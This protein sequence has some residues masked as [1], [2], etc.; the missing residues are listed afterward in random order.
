ML[1]RL[2]KPEDAL[3]VAPVHVRSWQVAYR[4]LLPDEYLARLHAEDRAPR[5]DFTHG[6]PL[7]PRTIVAADGAD[8]RGFATT[9]PARDKDLAGYGEL[10]ALYVDPED[11]GRGVGVA[12]I[13]AARELLVEAEFRNALLWVLAGNVRA[14]RFYERDGWSADGDSRTDV[15]WG[16]TVNEVRYRRELEAP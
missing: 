12:L 11:W 5:Y 3:A 1:L 10:C 6:D 14:M 9:M 7:K 8:I 15:V 2:A 13:N 4:G 16:A